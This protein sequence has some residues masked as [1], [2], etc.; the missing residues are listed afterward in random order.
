[1][2]RFRDTEI[3]NKPWYRKLPPAT[4]SAWDYITD[5]CDNVGVWVPDEEIVEI[6]VGAKVDW[7]ALLE[8]AN[9][10]IQ[11][12]PNGKWWLED[13]VRFQHGDLISGSQSNACKS[14]VNLLKTH[15]LYKLFPELFESYG[16]P[17]RSLHIGYKERER[18]KEGVKERE[19]EGENGAKNKIAEATR[20]VI[21]L[22][23][24]RGG[25]RYDVEAPG[26][27]TK[28]KRLLA[29]GY[30]VEQMRKV[31]A[32]KC[33]KWKGDP[34]MDDFLR[35]STLFGPEKFDDYVGEYDHEVVKDA[36]RA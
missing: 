11:V 17:S 25:F 24:E 2:K 8:R 33:K 34:K 3:W 36:E 5:H 10:N 31:V 20:D 13:F 6:F 19:Q 9:G 27:R 28:V 16:K 4:K 23:N 32:I 7:E 30:T 22:L 15:G 26:N 21:G 35:P 1:M 18:V 12:L 14:Y 29:K